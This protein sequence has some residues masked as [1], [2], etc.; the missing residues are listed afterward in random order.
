MLVSRSIENNVNILA[1]SQT[2]RNISSVLKCMPFNH[3]R[4]QDITDTI[5]IPCFVLII[6]GHLL[7]KD[8]RDI[9]FLE[10]YLNEWKGSM[11]KCLRCRKHC[12]CL[13]TASLENNID[14]GP[15]YKAPTILLHADKR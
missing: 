8:N 9:N 3:K 1:N 15:D 5:M 2:A 14:T 13:E 6:D 7:T 12:D 11:K 4:C 10:C